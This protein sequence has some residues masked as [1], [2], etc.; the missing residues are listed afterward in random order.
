MFLCYF[1]TSYQ[2]T[3]VPALNVIE[4]PYLF[5]DLAAAHAALDGPLGERLQ[6]AVRQATGFELLGFWDNGFRHLSNRLRPV[7]APSDCAGM[8]VRL[9]P[10]PYHEAM[11]EAWGATPVAVELSEGIRLI[12]AG[13]VDAQENPL[14]NAVAYGVDRVHR[15]FSM[16]GHLYG[17]RG[18]FVNQARLASLPPDVRSLVEEAARKAVEHQRRIAGETELR[19]RQEL[20]GGGLHFV[21]LAPEEKDAFGR[22]SIPAIRLAG[23]MLP[24]ELLVLAGARS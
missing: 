8:T 2:G 4:V 14:A 20:E 6:A 9:Q 24:P 21:D 7:R 16:T 11:I 1:S 12:T 5:P 17:A 22:A 10:N 19:L 18:L 13:S 23:Q 3:R 15:F